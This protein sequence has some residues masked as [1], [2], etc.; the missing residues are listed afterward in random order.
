MLR[1]AQARLGEAALAEDVVQEALA[2]ALANRHQFVGRAAL[3]SWVFAILRHKLADALRRRG[4]EPEQVGQEALD[5]PFDA[6]GRWRPEVRPA[7]WQDPERAFGQAQFWQVF[8]RCLDGLPPRQAQAFLLREGL[9][10]STADICAQLDIT[11]NHLNVMLHRARLRLRACLET[12]WFRAGE[13]DR[14][15]L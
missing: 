3:R 8:Q 2:G 1:Y 14:A 15:Q 11:A 7:P 10:W 5:S 13:G 4:A 6:D 12:H 9:G